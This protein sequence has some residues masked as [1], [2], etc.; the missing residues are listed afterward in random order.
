[1]YYKSIHS[2]KTEIHIHMMS[3]TSWKI[4]KIIKSLANNKTRILTDVQ[5]AGL[6]REVY[7]E[8]VVQVGIATIKDPSIKRRCYHLTNISC[9][10]RKK[11]LDTFEKIDP[12]RQGKFHF[13]CFKV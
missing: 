5:Q 3:V 2:W 7:S 6:E 13:Q 12:P 4:A 10:E 8:V 11:L 1:M 9:V